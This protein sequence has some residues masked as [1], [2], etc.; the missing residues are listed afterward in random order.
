M[1]QLVNVPPVLL[2]LLIFLVFC[3]RSNI[4]TALVNDST[5]DGCEALTLSKVGVFIYRT[6]KEPNSV[7]QEDDQK[8][9]NS[10]C[11]HAIVL[12]ELYIMECFHLA[13]AVLVFLWWL[14]KLAYRWRE[15][16]TRSKDNV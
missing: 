13:P 12:L 8:Q 6:L 7:A 2:V 16:H 11:V 14:V 9:R 4:T 3:G 15:L 10:F 1:L 5:G